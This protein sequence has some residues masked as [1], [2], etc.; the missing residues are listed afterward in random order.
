MVHWEITFLIDPFYRW[1]KQCYCCITK[2]CDKHPK[3]LARSPA[4][5]FSENSFSKSA[6]PLWTRMVMRCISLGFILTLWKNQIIWSRCP[7]NPGWKLTLTVQVRLTDVWI[8]VELS[9][10]MQSL[11]KKLNEFH[12][13]KTTTLKRIGFRKVSPIMIKRDSARIE[14]NVLDLR[15]VI[16]K[17]GSGPW[18]FGSKRFGFNVFKYCSKLFHCVFLSSSIRK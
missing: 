13:E 5:H 17:I 18:I 9:E 15:P 7:W 8:H 11:D 10:P 6:Q 3:W 16:G 14:Q 1:D 4:T 2:L 12:Q